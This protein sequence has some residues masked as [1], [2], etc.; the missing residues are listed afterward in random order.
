MH[1][2][3]LS[4][5][6][7]TFRHG[8]DVTAR[9][10][11]IAARQVSAPRYQT[12]F[13]TMAQGVVYHSADGTITTCNPAAEHILGMTLAQMQ[14]RT[15]LDPRWRAIHRDGSAFPGET[16]PAMVALRTG[17]VVRNVV[18]GVYDWEHDAYRWITINAVPRIRPGNTA[19]A[20]VY[21]TFDDITENVEAEAQ[22]R[23]ALVVEQAVRQSVEAASVRTTH[24]QALTADFAGALTRDDVIA[25][26]VG[27]GTLVANAASI[28]VILV[29]PSDQQPVYVGINGRSAV[30]LA[31][32]PPLML[33][34][35]PPLNVFLRGQVRV[36]VWLYSRDNA[37]AHFPGFGAIMAHYGFHAC[38]AFPLI[39][40]DVIV[41][42]I[43][44]CYGI[45]NAFGPEERAFLIAFVQQC[46]QALDRARLYDETV[47]ARKQLQQLSHRLLVAQEQ[48]RRHIARELHDEVGQA[49]GALKINLYMLGIQSEADTSRLAESLTIVDLLIMQVRALAL[50]L[51]PSVLDDLGLAAAL[52][53]YCERL[54]QRTDLVVTFTEQIKD[55][56]MSPLI[57]TTCFRIAQESL[58]NVVRHAHAQ[59]VNVTLSR[60]EEM[61]VLSVCDD[62][63][64][65]TVRD[66]LA[67]AVAGASLGLISMTERAE[68]AGGW[69]D[70]S[71]TPGDGAE[72][73]AWL[74]L[75]IKEN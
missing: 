65:F 22:V 27:Q 13:E 28:V 57:A 61:L 68:L 47:M 34:A 16:H 51:R 17:Q 48:E 3:K 24:L 52:A 67:R 10:R 46:T 75:D 21:A 71:S 45:P 50:D 53:W 60:H 40:T 25:V 23:A 59:R 2:P 38:A 14:G 70:I 6:I 31:T 5:W 11:V 49:L 18:M 37:E 43:S 15:S 35:P 56:P 30:N 19:A 58:T 4:S 55:A 39:T 54:Q 69:V 44:F 73:W 26:I 36:P 74:P 12:L 20:H 66:G 7:E 9:R 29:D 33:N 63:V 32:M 62:G 41:G 72:V 64:G 42:A 1:V 8:A